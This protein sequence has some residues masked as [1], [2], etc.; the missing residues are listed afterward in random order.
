MN[1]WLCVIIRVSV[2]F[3]YLLNYKLVINWINIVVFILTIHFMPY[4]GIPGKVFYLR[5]FKKREEI[6]ICSRHKL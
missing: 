3:I 4:E 2:Y 6:H 5:S 1:A